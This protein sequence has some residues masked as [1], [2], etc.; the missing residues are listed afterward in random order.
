MLA[1]LK[2]LFEN[3]T[4]VDAR[5]LNSDVE[6]NQRLA[7]AAL[8]IEVAIVDQ[9]FDDEELRTLRNILQEQFD[10]SS[11]DTDELIRMAKLECE[12]S[13]SMYQFTHLI[14]QHCTNENK[15]LLLVGMWQIA[16]ADGELDKYEEY[17]IR[18][19]AELIHVS[20]SD[21]IRAKQQ[22]KETLPQ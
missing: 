15:C 10:I 3:G 7:C 12:R 6:T 16:F 22:A 9:E 14:N 11:N 19:V 8:L 4:Q 21:F 17:V 2:S 18:K 1:A 20:H 13:T 5:A